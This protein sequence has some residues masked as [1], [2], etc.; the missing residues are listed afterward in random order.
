MLCIKKIARLEGRKT[1]FSVHKFRKKY[2][3]KIMKRILNNS[4]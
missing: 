3:S 1:R 4:T 2:V